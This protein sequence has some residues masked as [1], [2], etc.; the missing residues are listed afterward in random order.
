MSVEIPFE[1]EHVRAKLEELYTGLI[2]GTGNTADERDKNFRSKALAAFAIHKIAPCTVEESA[3]A[4]VDGGGDGGIDA[5]YLSLTGTDLLIVQSKFINSGRGEPTLGD[6]AK[7]R[8]GIE[9]LMRGHF[10]GFQANE[11]FRQ[12]LPD[13][14]AYLERTGVRVRVI[15][16][17][18][19]IDAVSEERI[20]IFEKLEQNFSHDEGDFSVRSYNLTSVH[21]WLSG[22]DEAPGVNVTLKLCQPARITTPAPFEMY[23]GLVRLQEL[24]ALYARH[25]ALLVTANIREY[26]GR[27]VVNDH[28]LETLRETPEHFAYLNN[29]LTAYCSSIK[30]PALDRTNHAEKRLEL[31]RFC[32][33]NGAQTLGSINQFAAGGQTPE[34]FAF[35]KIISL[36]RCDN[37]QAFAERITRATNLQNQ[38]NLQDFAALDDEQKRIAAHLELS[39]I[40]YHY[41]DSVNT[42]DSDEATFN[43]EEALLALACLDVSFTS[44]T[45][46][47]DELTDFLCAH[48]LGN[49][50][51]LRSG[52]TVYHPDTEEHR[53]RYNRIFRPNR[54]ARTTWRAVQTKR[55]VIER[56]QENT[57][58]T[59]RTDPRKAF[60]ENARWFVLN[61]VFLRLHPERGEALFLSAE[62][63][64]RIRAATDTISEALWVEVQFETRHAKT[65]FSSVADC[66]RFKGAVQARLST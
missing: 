37:E 5:V 47:G 36:E 17:Y 30:L 63:R 62:E 1:L 49:R 58:A 56:M 10:D 54:S 55:I 6:V 66:V 19:G 32:V 22:A 35:I 24:A 34:G 44:R 42:P 59:A 4:I 40:H 13:I 14:R 45:E 15:L 60:F 61:L 41:R 65:V 52:A 16:V 50:N 9:N 33:I 7:F 26:K 64:E 43:F 53:S 8:E 25:G 51:A 57:R 18:S 23:Y 27:T 48:A 12:I 28:I 31:T 38:V 3:R 11:T 20:R 46:S 29:G 2:V 39:G 21:G